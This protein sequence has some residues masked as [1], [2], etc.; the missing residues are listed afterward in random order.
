MTYLIAAKYLAKVLAST[1]AIGI[2]TASTSGGVASN[3]ELTT[4]SQETPHDRYH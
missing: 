1:A 2:L 4:Q 3:P